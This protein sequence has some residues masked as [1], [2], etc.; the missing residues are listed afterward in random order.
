LGVGRYEGQVDYF[1]IRVRPRDARFR[2]K[3]SGR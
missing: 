1:L 3:P 2:Y